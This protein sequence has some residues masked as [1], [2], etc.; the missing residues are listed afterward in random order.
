[1]QIST[2]EATVMLKRFWIELRRQKLAGKRT[3]ES[4]VRI[5]EAMA[6]LRLKT[7]IDTQIALEAQESIRV[8]ET[9]L[10][11]YVKVV[12]DPRDAA[13]A[14]VKEIVENTKSA[15]A[16]E[17]AAR[18]ACNENE[19]VKS[20]LMGG[21]NKELKTDNNKRFREVH[22]RFIQDL[23]RPD[24]KILMLRMSPLVVIWQTAKV[25]DVVGA[26]ADVRNVNDQNDQNDQGQSLENQKSVLPHGHKF[27]ESLNSEKNDNSDT[28][29]RTNFCNSEVRDR[30]FGSF[31]SFSSPNQNPIKGKLEYEY[32]ELVKA[33]RCL[34]C[35]GIYSIDKKD[36]KESHPC[37]YNSASR[38]K[39]SIGN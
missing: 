25:T 18:L 35:R 34:E 29:G 22:D 7:V 8:M 12:Q 21:P 32:L 5:T 10:G 4:I 19:H 14:A 27:T 33:Y 20:W 37:N 11:Q 36:L 6:K 17:E 30:S 31:R 9:R 28:V 3:F 23:K 16:F 38:V 24:S 15:I 2:P 1:M 13:I 39:G 26:P